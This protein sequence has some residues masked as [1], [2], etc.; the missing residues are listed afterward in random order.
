MTPRTGPFLL[1]L[2]LVACLPWSLSGCDRPGPTVSKTDPPEL[3]IASLSPALTQA[4]IDFDCARHLVGCTPYAPPGVEDVP[5]VGD[6][7]SPNL[8]R[9][10]VVSPTL[11]LVQ[12]S[13]SGIDPDL[14]SLAETRG[15]RIASWRI[16]RLSDIGRIVDE[17][18]ELLIDLGVSA[19]PIESTVGAWR[20]RSRELL[21]PVPAFSALG[22]VVVLYGVDPPSAFGTD[23]YVDDVLVS[24][25]IENAVR[26][27][28]YPDLSLEDLL[29]LAPDT[30]VVLGRDLESAQASA[31]QLA[32][33][34]DALADRARFLGA[35][36][37]KLL[38]PGTG[39][40][41]GVDS[42][43]NRLLRALA[44]SNEGG[45]S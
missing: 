2:L 34:L 35:D 20:E 32:G 29:V 24:L 7:L 1:V 41:D 9:L 33:R 40:L 15:W 19:Q 4:L 5:V 39:V 25:G 17:L 16:D 43:R 13:S 45:A 22:R 6:L 10:L 44:R 11:L 42:L 27:P 23:T 14:A 18:P 8:E 21:T 38:I 31:D 30:V 12:P 28:G 36:G 3:R 37:S 26:R